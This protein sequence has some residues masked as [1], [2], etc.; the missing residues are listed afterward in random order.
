A[1]DAGTKPATPPPPPSQAHMATILKEF[2]SYRHPL[3]FTKRNIVIARDP[4]LEALVALAKR[5]HHDDPESRFM[6][7]TDGDEKQS[8]RYMAFP[9]N[10]RNN[11]KLRIIS[12]ILRESRHQTFIPIFLQILYLRNVGCTCPAKSI[13]RDL[14]ES[15][16]ATRLNR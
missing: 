14:F 7:F 5:R 10:R 13:E 16:Y 8:R 2:P 1:A 11:A 15:S 4:S 6:I 9:K 3:R 12:P